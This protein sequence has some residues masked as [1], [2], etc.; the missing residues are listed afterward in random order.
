MNIDSFVN[1]QIRN[2][3]VNYAVPHRVFS[4]FVF[5]RELQIHLGACGESPV[6]RL[7]GS[8]P[9]VPLVHVSVGSDGKDVSTT[10]LRKGAP[11]VNTN[12]TLLY[13]G[14]LLLCFVQVYENTILRADAGAIKVMAIPQ[15]DVCDN[16]CRAGDCTVKGYVLIVPDFGGCY[17]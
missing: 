5:V 12:F 10:T 13:C 6:A 17:H 16:E 4:P 2:G 3:M 7:G 9:A 15:G 1:V 14:T 8:P 11:T